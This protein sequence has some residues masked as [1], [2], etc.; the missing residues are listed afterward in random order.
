MLLEE[1][2]WQIN[3][4]GVLEKEGQ[5]LRLTILTDNDPE[6]VAIGQEIA[7]Q[8]RA[9]GVDASLEARAWS[10]LVSNFLVPRRFQAALYGWDQGY[11]P[12]PYPA[13]H[14]SQ[15]QERGL[16]LAGYSDEYLDRVLS[17]ARQTSDL[18]QRKALYREFQQIFAEEVPS[19]LLFYPVYN[20]FI[21]KEVKGV[22]L[23]VLFESP[24]RFANVHQWYVKAKR[25]GSS[26]SPEST[27]WRTPSSP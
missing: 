8:V 13:W 2:G 19:I 25:T 6:R 16:N 7:E 18:E 23:G 14:S 3:S 21:D 24:S 5:E 10:D 26:P 22:S 27:S 4:R 17:Q 12:D 15:G 9:V 11:D 20:Y 1:D